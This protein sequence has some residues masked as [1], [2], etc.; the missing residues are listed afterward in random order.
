MAITAVSTLSA[1]IV[2][3]GHPLVRWAT[4]AANTYIPGN[5]VYYNATGTVTVIDT[6]TAACKLLHPQLLNFVP[7]LNTSTK[8]RLDVDN[9]YQD[10]TTA[11][12]DVIWGGDPGPLLVVGCVEDPGGAFL[13]GNA[14]MSAA[15]TAGDLLKLNSGTDPTS[16]PV[17]NVSLWEDLANQQTKGIFIMR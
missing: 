15:T 8:A 13:K 7:R 1:T 10:Q 11:R 6:D 12:A 16:L 4:L 14:F 3:K 5:W 2:R 9:D 17:P